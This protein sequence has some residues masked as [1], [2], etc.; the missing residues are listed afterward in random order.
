MINGFRVYNGGDILP[1]C[2]YK[3]HENNKWLVHAPWVGHTIMVHDFVLEHDDGTITCEIYGGRVIQG[4][5]YYGS[6][7]ESY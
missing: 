7:I 5:F 3:K 6:E 1:S 4:N 2:S